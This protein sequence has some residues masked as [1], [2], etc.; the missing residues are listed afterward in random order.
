MS[1]VNKLPALWAEVAGQWASSLRLRAGLTGIVLIVWVYV[2]LL[3]ADQVSALRGETQA[4]REELARIQPL[5]REQGWTQ[6]AEDARQQLAAAQA[7]LWVDTD[8][9]L[10]EARFQDWLRGTAS[11]AGLSLRELSLQRGN[12]TLR[13]GGASQVAASEPLALGAR[14]VVDLQ[15]LPLLAFLAEVGRNE[16]VIVIE[17]LSLRPGAQPALAEIELR[18]LGRARVLEAGSEVKP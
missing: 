11:K 10:I 3:V 13:A 12:A 18:V 7:M 1:A 5:A 4:L 15:R 9:G 6:R 17:R 14:M 8:A 2:L 16:Q